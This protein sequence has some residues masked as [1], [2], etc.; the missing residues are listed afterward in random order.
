MKKFLIV[1]ATIVVASFIA[2][3]VTLAAPA[4][5]AYAASSESALQGGGGP[6]NAYMTYKKVGIT[7]REY[8][9][10]VNGHN[11]GMLQSFLS[12]WFP[13]WRLLRVT[14]CGN[15]YYALI[16]RWSYMSVPLL[17]VP[18]AA[19]QGGYCAQYPN[20]RGCPVIVN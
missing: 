18:G 14:Q 8:F 13:G 7:A 9:N 10:Y 19:V 11:R 4:T 3:T 15:Y 17:L 20:A 5:A 1:I 16:S 2:S 6:P 12:K